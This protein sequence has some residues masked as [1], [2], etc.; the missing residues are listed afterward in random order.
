MLRELDFIPSALL[1]MANKVL[2][3]IKHIVTIGTDKYSLRAPDI[4]TNVGTLVGV[5]KAPTPDNTNYKG[6]IKA[7]DFADGKVIRI[8]SRGNVVGSNGTVT[9]SRTFTFVVP[10]EK[11]RTALADID[12]K[13]VTIDGKNYDLGEARIPQRRRFS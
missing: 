9:E 4:Y 1:Q 10:M 3:K 5:T 12:A 13:Q 8:R 11:A 7:A 2:K 6:K